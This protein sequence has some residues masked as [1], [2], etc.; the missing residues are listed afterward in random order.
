MPTLEGTLNKNGSQSQHATVWLLMT[1][2]GTL[3]ARTK[4]QLSLVTLLTLTLKKGQGRDLL[5]T[6]EGTLAA[7]TKC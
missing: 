4:C 3:A 2:E 7:R 5:M 6:L 1:L